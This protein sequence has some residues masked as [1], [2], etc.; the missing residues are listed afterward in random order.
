MWEGLE[1]PPG[2]PQSLHLESVWLWAMLPLRS[3]GYSGEIMCEQTGPAPS[4][5][6]SQRGFVPGDYIILGSGSVYMGTCVTSKWQDSGYSRWPFCD[7]L[8]GGFTPDLWQRYPHLGTHKVPTSAQTRGA[9]GQPRQ[10]ALLHK[11][12][13]RPRLKEAPPAEA[14]PC[15]SVIRLKGSVC[16][17]SSKPSQMICSL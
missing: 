8:G 16:R 6:E 12:T 14:G 10:G 15:C 1:E 5:G 3:H 13:Q 4:M 9:V 7:S 2:D 11:V 17:C